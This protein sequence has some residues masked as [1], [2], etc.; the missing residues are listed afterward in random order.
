MPKIENDKKK[1]NQNN[2]TLARIMRVSVW[3]QGG[4][5]R[6]LHIEF[7]CSSLLFCVCH[8]EFVRR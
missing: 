2:T 8:L 1:K 6:K 7:F 3:S 4:M 5:E